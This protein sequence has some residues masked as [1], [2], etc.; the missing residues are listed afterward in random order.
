MKTPLKY[1]SIL[2]LFVASF[3][4]AATYRPLI[5]IP[6]SMIDSNG[7]PLS[8]GVLYA[9]TTGTTTPVTVYQDN[10]GTV[11]GTSVTLDARGEPTTF[12]RIWIDTE[13]NYKFVL[14]DGYGVTIWTQDPV[15]GSP[16]GRA[17]AMS[18]T[19]TGGTTSRTLANHLGDRIN[20]KDFGAVAD[21]G[22]DD[23][24]EIQAAIDGYAGGVTIYMPPGK[25]DI[26]STIYLRR[27][28]VKLVG[29]GVGATQVT[30]T[31][32]AGGTAFDGTTNGTDVLQDC[33]LSG[34]LLFGDVST[35]PSV[36]IDLVNFSY[37][38][39][40]LSVQSKRASAKLY[41]GAGNNGSQ[42]YYNHITGYL[43]GGTDK[44]QTGIYFGA[45]AWSGGSP[46]PNSNVIGPIYRAASLGILADIAAG[47]GNTFTDIHAESIGDYYFRL[48]NV[49]SYSDTG[50]STGSNGAVTLNNTGKSYTTNQFVNYGIRIT[51]GTGAGQSRIIK[52]NSATVITVETPW[53]VWPDATS[54]YV[55]AA[56]HS[57]SN[58]FVNIRAEGNSSDNPD[59]IYALPGA[60]AN[61]FSGVTVESLGSGL[62]ARDESGAINNKWFDGSKTCFTEAV[63][64]PGASANIDIYPR[65]SGFGGV[66][67][68]NYSIEWL[69]ATV[70]AATPG[71]TATIRLDVGGTSAGTGS[72]MTLTVKTSGDIGFAT[73]TNIQKIERDGTNRHVFLNVQTGASYSATA[74]MVIT[75]CATVDM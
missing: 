16:V 2:L 25:Y 20:V 42:P 45:G 66:M 74:D 54:T 53:G 71:D 69:N 75:W 41:S 57:H 52:S 63:I 26:S 6:I 60:Y 70:N 64:N 30:Y 24:D 10:S 50:T 72:D 3:V 58:K 4:S 49:T 68:S 65:N 7:D 33:E 9:Y 17:T 1:L 40:D 8:G 12:K 11:A 14:K 55:I 28:S 22:I 38:R 5:D 51:G 18:V 44:T 43:F 56:N 34:F 35:G 48:N 67:L 37:S 47:N 29:A 27:N 61:T 36:G 31:N 32:A 39:F 46:G 13:V 23:T 62:W 19:A 21:D 59:F 15:Y 73:P